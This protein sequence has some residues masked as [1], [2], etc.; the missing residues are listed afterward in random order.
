LFLAVFLVVI[1]IGAFY[2]LVLPVLQSAPPEYEAIVDNG[3]SEEVS[4]SLDPAVDHFLITPDG[5]I[6]IYVQQGAFM[7]GG[8]LML[9]PRKDAFLPGQGSTDVVR[10]RGVDLVIMREDGEVLSHVDLD[11][12]ILLCYKV[13]EVLEPLYSLDPNIYTIQRY[14]DTRVPSLWVDLEPAPGWEEKQVCSALQELSLYAITARLPE[15]VP[16]VPKL[17]TPEPTEE[18]PSDLYGIPTPTP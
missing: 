6:A 12:P 7:N 5:L 10:I 15:A 11:N 14:D 3:E 13:D 8:T 18:G 4:V 1:L 16:V 2:F 17:V 9:A